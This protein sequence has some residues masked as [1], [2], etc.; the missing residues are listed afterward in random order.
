MGKIFLNIWKWFKSLSIREWILVGLF[1]AVSIACI[2][3]Y[4]SDRTKII[5]VSEQ[6]SYYQNKSNEEYKAKTILLQ[7]IKDLKKSNDSLYSE[8]LKIKNDKPL[9]ITKTVTQFKIDTLKILTTI[10]KK[11]Q[12]LYDLKWSY[13][14]KFDSNNY[15]SLKGMTSVD[16]NFVNANTTLENLE[17]GSDIILDLIEGNSSNSVR[18]VTRSNNPRISFTNIEG[19]ILDPT[20]NSLIKNCFPTKHWGLG[21]SLGAGIGYDLNSKKISVGPQLSV[22]ITY[23]ILTW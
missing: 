5:T 11:N 18:I 17:I 8:Y 14:E 12:G 15:L 3:I 19:A 21:V 13:S 16:T 7:E 2:Q 10:E 23:N 6:S 20:K 9:I 1:L 22:G 4:V